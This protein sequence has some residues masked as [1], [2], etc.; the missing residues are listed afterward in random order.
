MCNVVL[1]CSALLLC[2]VALMC[3]V[4]LMCSVALMCLHIYIYKLEFATTFEML[5]V[6]FFAPYQSYKLLKGF[7]MTPR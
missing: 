7:K 1:I 6:W 3:S 4:M 2:N 5:P